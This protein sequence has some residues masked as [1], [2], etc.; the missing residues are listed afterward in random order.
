MIEKA[1]L[2]GSGKRSTRSSLVSLFLFVFLF[3]CTQNARAEWVDWILYGQ[4]NYFYTDNINYSATK[5]DEAK[6][7][8][9]FGGFG[10]LGRVYQLGDS[11]RLYATL[12]LGGQLHNEWSTL[13]YSEIG[14]NLS[15]RHKFGLGTQQFWLRGG[16]NFRN[17]F[18]KS[19]IRDGQVYTGEFSIGKRLHERINPQA[20]YAFD[21]R[22][23]VNADPIAEWEGKPTGLTGDVFNHQ[24][25]QLKAKVDV[26]VSNT[27]LLIGNYA[28]RRGDATSTC[29]PT[30]FG[31]ALNGGIVSAATID[32]VFGGCAYRFDATTHTIGIDLNQAFLSGHGAFNIGYQFGTG[33]AH[34]GMGYDYRNNI[35]RVNLMFNY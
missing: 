14:G 8:N 29:T 20:G 35:F 11:T 3:C 9:I 28:F 27:A 7:D 24:G 19:I 6:S 33:D 32:D 34:N 30:S 17:I 13:D 16:F 4:F 31:M 10:A 23:G 2:C 21:A 26:L 15:I 1:V 22:D 5:F 18:S 25:N 12:N